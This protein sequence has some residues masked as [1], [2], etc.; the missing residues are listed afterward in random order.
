LP[1]ELCNSWNQPAS[2]R[3]TLPTFG[4]GGV[5]LPEQNPITWRLHL[6][7]RPEEVFSFLSTDEGRVKFWCESS[8]ERGTEIQMTFINGATCTCTVTASQPPSS[9][10]ITY[11]G[12]QV[13][14]RLAGDA[15]GG[16]DLTVI[17]KGVP[18]AEWLEVYAGWLNVL[19]PLKAAVDFDIDLRNHDRKRTWDQGYVDA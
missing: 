11:F 19:L 5:I 1:A 17:N 2:A 16:T 4:A 8:R 15:N 13:E 6:R 18:E 7:S 3:I 14:F 9:F 12:S 10:A